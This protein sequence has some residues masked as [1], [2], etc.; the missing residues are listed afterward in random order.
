MTESRT[1]RLKPHERTFTRVGVGM[2]RPIEVKRCRSLFKPHGVMFTCYGICAIHIAF[3]LDSDSFINALGRELIWSEQNDS[4]RVTSQL[5]ICL[6]LDRKCYRKP[7][8][9]T[10]ILEL[11]HTQDLMQL[12]KGTTVK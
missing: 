2:F 8:T 10:L 3:S 7:F 5:G 11:D 1:G 6:I 12:V 4:L 9:G